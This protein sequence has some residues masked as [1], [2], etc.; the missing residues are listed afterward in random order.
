[1][2]VYRADG[3]WSYG[4]DILAHDNYISVNRTLIK[5]IG[6]SCAVLIGELIS[7]AR[8]YATKDMLEDG[9]FYSTVDNISNRC[10]LSK[11]QQGEALK[12]LT[13]LGLVE[14]E[15]RGIP[16]RRYVR[17]DTVRTIEIINQCQKPKNPQ[18]VDDKSSGFSPTS[19]PETGQQ[20]GEKPDIKKHKKNPNN[21]QEESKQ[22]ETIKPCRAEGHQEEIRAIIDHLN[23][24]LG[25]SYTYRNKET[26]KHI[27]A[28]LTE[29]YTVDDF[30]LVI[31]T[32]ASEWR[33]TKWA[34]Y[35][36]PK[37]LF[38]PSHFEEYLNQGRMSVSKN[39]KQADF[40]DILDGWDVEY[41]GGD[42]VA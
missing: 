36:R 39:A 6:L 16:R 21:K 26:N 20:A 8:Y 13:E 28:R 19:E 32:K 1:M 41:R 31:D 12:D 22:Q 29:K 23:E 17:V 18:R 35:L 10:G 24:V 37:T 3:Y 14:V 15:Y 38:S 4:L 7:E 34:K 11:H 42:H 25:T 9:W 40:N 30:W 27:V 2:T 5:A 33:G